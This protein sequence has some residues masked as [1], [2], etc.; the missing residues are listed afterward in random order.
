MV[1][2]QYPETSCLLDLSNKIQQII[3]TNRTVNSPPV[4]LTREVH[5]ETIAH[6]IIH[7]G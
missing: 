5:P 6:T 7:I 4:E 3:L 2:Q 1:L